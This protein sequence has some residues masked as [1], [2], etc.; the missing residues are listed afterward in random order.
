MIFKENL[1]EKQLLSKSDK[2]YQAFYEKFCSSTTEQREP[3]VVIP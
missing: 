3:T 2:K 1:S